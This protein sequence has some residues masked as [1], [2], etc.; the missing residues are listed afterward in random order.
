VIRHFD[1]APSRR[2][3][4]GDMHAT[5]WSLGGQDLPAGALRARIDPGARHMPFHLHWA[6]EELFFV[7]EGDGVVVAGDAT[8]AVAAGDCVLRA[9]G[10]AAHAFYA[11]EGGMDL[12]CFGENLDPAVVELPRAGVVRRGPLWWERGRGDP[13][14]REVA[15]GP[16]PR[17]A[18]QPRPP[19]IV[20]R[21]DVEAD[22]G[23]PPG[24][25]GENRSLG[26]A[27]GAR[28]TGLHLARLEPGALSCPPHRHSHTTELYVVLEGAGELGL[29]DLEGAETGRAPLRAGDV[30]V[31]APALR[32]AHA[33]VA[34]DA[35]LTYLAY[36]TRDPGETVHY[37]RSGKL[38][39]NG[40][41]LRVE[42]VPDYW[43]G[44]V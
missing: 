39:V 10:D 29:W 17:G 27:A 34:G 13:L 41:L 2:R 42:R 23:F 33:L 20:H 44:E 30:V 7:L 14:A 32:E 22:T 24:Y 37:P 38:A 3:D 21:D 26:A 4:D 18:P 1:E 6:E 19:W 36:G 25:G 8:H 16:V 43:E 9:P 12:L 31:R 35:G 15:A 5:L 11:G 28:R 40:V